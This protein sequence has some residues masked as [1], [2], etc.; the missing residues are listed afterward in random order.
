MSNPH[1]V[2]IP[3]LL[4]LVINLLRDFLWKLLRPAGRLCVPRSFI[5]LLSTI[6]QDGYGLGD[7]PT[8]GLN[9]VHEFLGRPLIS[10]RLFVWVDSLEVVDCV[11][12]LLGP[13]CQIP[14]LAVQFL[15][16]SFRRVRWPYRRAAWPSLFNDNGTL[17]LN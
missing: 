8:F 9:D 15:D 1:L 4:D 7:F 13:G 3:Y 17:F 11:L 16:L 10:I 14:R 2:L 6:S 12:D 5:Y